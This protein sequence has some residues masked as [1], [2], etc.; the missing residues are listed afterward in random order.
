MTRREFIALLGGSAVTSPFAAQA[1]QA[2]VPVIGF[3][4]LG[5]D[6]NVS[7]E[8]FRRGLAEEGY[9]DDHNVK[10]EYRWAHGQYDRLAGLAMDLVRRRVDVIVAGGTSAPGLAAK[11]ATSTI[12]IVFQTGSDP[13]ADQLV[14]S[15]NRSG[16][17]ITGVSRMTVMLGP[18]LLELLREVAPK[19]NAFG[20]L[21]HR[22]NPHA[23]VMMEQ[24]RKAA[25]AL[26]VRLTMV[27][28]NDESELGTAFRTMAQQSTD[29]LLIE[30][31]PAIERWMDRIVALTTEHSMPAIANNR[32]FVIA[33]GLMSYDA[34]LGDSFRQVGVYVGR[35]L[36]GEKPAN[37]PVMQPTKFD[38]VINLKSAK[39]LG[40]TVPP[41][42]I[43]R[44]NEAIE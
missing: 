15:M 5:S 12:P 14:P 30:N 19:A 10:V 32:A 18:K 29:A 16:G 25:L 3:L 22:N 37:L 34:S 11:A 31:D 8:G 17:N 41:Q 20:F 4:N 35:V 23:G 33:G 7:I 21:M 39:A 26:G 40:L 44:A 13:V 6:N 42:L 43:A 9:S 38:L 28:L 36:K 24:F 2:V 1:Q 27:A